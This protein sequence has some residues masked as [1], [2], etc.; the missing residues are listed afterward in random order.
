MRTAFADEDT[1]H[2]FSMDAASR[3]GVI[4]EKTA[5]NV[6]PEGVVSIRPVKASLSPD[7]RG[8]RL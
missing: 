4:V 1:T 7:T 8:R 3:M 5:D 2:D 6:T